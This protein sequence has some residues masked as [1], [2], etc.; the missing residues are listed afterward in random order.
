MGQ[1]THSPLVPLH[2]LRIETVSH[3]GKHQMHHV[4][5]AFFSQKNKNQWRQLK[6]IQ[7]KMSKAMFIETLLYET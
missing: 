2:S 5:A 3:K 1:G 6:K 4:I 7:V